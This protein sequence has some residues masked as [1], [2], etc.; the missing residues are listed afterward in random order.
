MEVDD[1]KCE[2]WL[3]HPTDERFSRS[4]W[5]AFPDAGLDSSHNYCRNPN[6]E[7]SGPWCYTGETTVEGWGYCRV[8]FCFEVYERSAVNGEPAEGYPECRQTEMGKEYVG[9]ARRTVTGKPCL[10]WD[11]YSHS[12]PKTD[13]FDH[14]ISYGAHFRFGDPKW[15]EDFCRNPTLKERPWCLVDDP[16]IIWEFCDIPLCPNYPHKTECRWTRHGEEYAG[17]RK[18]T[19]SGRP[20][21]PWSLSE[22]I[23]LTWPR[24]PEDVREKDHNFCRNPGMDPGRSAMSFKMEKAWT[25]LLFLLIPLIPGVIP[26]DGSLEYQLTSPGKRYKAVARE[27]REASSA[28]CAVKCIHADPKAPCGAF[29]FRPSDGSCQL[30]S[31]RNHEMIPADGYLAFTHLRDEVVYPECRLTE[32]G[33]E[34]MGTVSVTETGKPCLRWDSSNVASSYS[35]VGKGFNDG[36]FF[37]EHFLNQDP[38]SHENFCRNPTLNEKP[39][40][41]IEEDDLKWESCEIPLCNDR[42]APECKLS[43][44]G[45]EYMGSKS[46][47]ISGFPC[48]PWLSWEREI[49]EEMFAE[50]RQVF[51][52]ILTDEHN[53]CRN[54]TGKPGGPWCNIQKPGDSENAWEYCDVRFCAQKHTER[55]CE[56]EG[57]CGSSES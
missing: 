17:T 28:S 57:G 47:T 39:W 2:P 11:T 8:P 3:K 5:L 20:C 46:Q 18:L 50:R 12:Y 43:Q 31:S 10:R 23:E 1:F 30:I 9:T 53:F 51:P 41:F 14:N 29:N 35:T 44:K 21:L 4:S 33:K 42:R 52:D 48:N 40:C 22:L 56:T 38:S 25:Q 16:D 24:F 6:R 27:S 34:Y 45:A 55:T 26:M 54:P 36:M 37:D 49:L 15:E 7:R 32:K 19:M 13:D